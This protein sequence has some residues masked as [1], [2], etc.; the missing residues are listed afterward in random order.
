MTVVDMGA[1]IRRRSRPGSGVNPRRSPL[2]VLENN[3]FPL[4]LK[5]PLILNTIFP[6][7]CRSRHP[8]QYK[9]CLRI[10]GGGV[11]GIRIQG[12]GLRGFNY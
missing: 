4:I 12:S 8:A 6:G 2:P 10:R 7:P 5:P 9:T 1:R 11:Q 3:R